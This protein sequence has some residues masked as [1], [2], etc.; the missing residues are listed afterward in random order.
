MIMTFCC[1]S[2]TT[3]AHDLLLSRPNEPFDPD[4]EHINTNS[5]KIVQCCNLPNRKSSTACKVL[6][7]KLTR[8]M[9]ISE[10]DA[11]PKY[12]ASQCFAIS[13]CAASLQFA[14]ACRLSLSSA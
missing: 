7:Q 8:H 5:S 10:H 12:S 14:R 1:K 9:S 11:H 3:H 2:D 4:A 6:L 13:L